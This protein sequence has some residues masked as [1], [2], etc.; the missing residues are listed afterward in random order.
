MEGDVMEVKVYAL[1]SMPFLIEGF[2]IVPRNA[3]L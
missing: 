3:S 2:P 1:G